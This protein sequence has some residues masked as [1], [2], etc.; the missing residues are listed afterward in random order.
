MNVIIFGATGG[1]GR[2]L[3]TQALAQGHQVTAFVRTPHALDPAAVARAVA[4]HDAVLNTLGGRPGLS[5]ALTGRPLQARVCATGT[6]YI[7][8]AME[9]HGV[10]RIVCE[11]MHGVGDSRSQTSFWRRLVFDR[12]LVGLFLQDEVDDK[13]RQEQI[14][15]QSSCDWIIVRPTQLTDGPHTGVYRV[16][17]E[18]H[19]GLRAKV[20]RADVAAFMLQQ[21]TDDTY[22]RRTPGISN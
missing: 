12:V 6:Q 19:L 13:Q 18:L 15:Q 20:T 1:T 7:L 5:R 4:G 10:R 3:V 14:I 9:Q 17:T 21:L 2:C 8:Q 16:G 11:T 22:L